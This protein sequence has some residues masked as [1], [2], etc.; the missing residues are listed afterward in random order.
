MM[1]YRN[2]LD[3]LE[4]MRERDATLL[5]H[6]VSIK[7]TDDEY[8][9]VENLFITDSDNEYLNHSVPVLIVS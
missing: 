8:F 3:A 1:T 5:N 9:N 2:L 7:V 6:K 4:L